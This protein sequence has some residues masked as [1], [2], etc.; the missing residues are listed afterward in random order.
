[1]GLSGVLGKAKM[2][3]D[4]YKHKHEL[5]C[6]HLIVVCNNTVILCYSKF[7]ALKERKYM[8]MSL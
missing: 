5:Y 1:M 4:A 6:V 7:R 3:V 2:H 8:C